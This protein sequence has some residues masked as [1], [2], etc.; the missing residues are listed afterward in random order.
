MSLFKVAKSE[1]HQRGNYNRLQIQLATGK[2]PSS[3]M[4]R[5]QRVV[6]TTHWHICLLYIHPRHQSKEPIF[7]THE[8]KRQ[9]IL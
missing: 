3:I 9:V 2:L 8:L 6:A 1:N 4:P 7:T 5:G